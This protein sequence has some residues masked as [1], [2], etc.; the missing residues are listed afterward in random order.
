MSFKTAKDVGFD[1]GPFSF[2]MSIPARSPS[3]SFR[4]DQQNRVSTCK[5]N[6]L[7]P[8]CLPSHSLAERG[9]RTKIERFAVLKSPLS[10]NPGKNMG[11]CSCAREIVA[12]P[13]PRRSQ[14]ARMHGRP[15]H[16]RRP[17]RPWPRPTGPCLAWIWR[18]SPRF[19][20]PVAPHRAHGAL[21]APSPPRVFHAAQPLHHTPTSDGR[22]NS[23]M[24][25]V[26]PR[27][28]LQ[29]PSMPCTDGR[30]SG[31]ACV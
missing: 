13:P 29:P 28:A 10:P 31:R 6:R 24:A 20:W 22:E 14:G 23:R 12:P 25:P 7:R 9:H 8:P 11:S 2:K 4:L 3:A 26:G 15:R 18:P 30:E 19:S 16:A 5:Q 27:R 21:L 1:L 17:P